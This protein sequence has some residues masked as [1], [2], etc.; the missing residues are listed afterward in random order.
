MNRLSDANIHCWRA[1]SKEGLTN[2]QAVDR[3]A[4]ATG[5]RD[6]YWGRLIFSDGTSISS[7]CESRGHFYREPG[8]RYDTRYIQRRERLGRFSLSCWSWMP[9]AGVGVL[10]RIHGR[11]NAPQYQ[12][13]FEN[14][15][16]RS[17]RVRNPEGNL[18][19]QQKNHP[20]RCSMG[21]Q[22]WFT[23][24]PEID[25]IPWPPKSPDLNVV[26]HTLA[27]LK[28]GRILRYGNNPTLNPQ[29]LWDQVVEIW[30]KLAQD[31]DYCLTLVD[32]IPRRCQSVT[33]AGGMWTRY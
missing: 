31:H 14:V 23:R 26:E 32:S 20:V 2:G 17:V 29:Q 3:L 7:D 5:W 21:V 33:D 4:L 8:T 22:R 25:L 28:E 19:F 16:L 11:F 24:R 1:A 30:D 27:K 10:E 6:F 18:I 15:M 13:I 9:H 12:H